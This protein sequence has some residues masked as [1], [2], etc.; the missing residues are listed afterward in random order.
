MITNIE[1]IEDCNKVI[2]CILLIII[3]TRIPSYIYSKT[4]ANFTLF[5]ILHNR[6]I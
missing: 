5:T 6:Y 1:K 4:L 2:G 3:D